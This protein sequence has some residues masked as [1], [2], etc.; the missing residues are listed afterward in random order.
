MAL[1]EEKVKET[2]G[3]CKSAFGLEASGKRYSQTKRTYMPSFRDRHEKL[4]DIIDEILGYKD[5]IEYFG[6]QAD[7]RKHISQINKHRG[8]HGNS[9]RKDSTITQYIPFPR[10]SPAAG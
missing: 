8:K 9:N 3:L 1:L 7:Y 10:L 5:A 4:R 6:F 2:I